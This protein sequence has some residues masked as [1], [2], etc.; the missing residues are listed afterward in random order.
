MRSFFARLLSLGFGGSSFV[1]C[2]GT[3]QP[4]DS[5]VDILPW[6][7]GIL[8]PAHHVEQAEMRCVT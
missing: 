8:Q 3:A 2:T 5:A 7:M 1:T 4:V 6:H